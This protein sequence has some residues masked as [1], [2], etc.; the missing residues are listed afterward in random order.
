MNQSLPFTFRDK[1]LFLVGMVALIPVVAFSLGTWLFGYYLFQGLQH[2]PSL[3]ILTKHM[4]AFWKIIL[5]VL[6]VSAI[7]GIL[8][9]FLLARRLSRKIEDLSKGANAWDRGELDY[10]IT[11]NYQD[12]IGILAQTLNQ[13]ADKLQ[14]NMISR[15]A[16]ENTFNAIPDLIFLLDA[17]GHITALN[18][19]AANFLHLPAS[20]VRGLHFKD[21]GRHCHHP[22]PFTTYHEMLAA[23]G[24]RE[25][26]WS[27]DLT[28]QTWLTVTYPRRD[29]ENSIIG[30]VHVIRNITV[31]KQAQAELAQT[32]RFLHE[33]LE[34]APLTI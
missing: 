32:T 21:L 20:K 17:Q 7:V 11:A 16:W 27:D 26:E 14:D 13:M 25:S 3:M 6:A 19:A 33:I 5:Q 15:S 23:Q 30:G 31:L 24:R 4:S 29:Q 28:G 8:A 34:A 22:P 1:L 18:Q 10:R 12:E 9:G 2:Q